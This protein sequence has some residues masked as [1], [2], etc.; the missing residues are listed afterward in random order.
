[1]L[2]IS[3]E[4]LSLMVPFNGK[5]SKIASMTYVPYMSLGNRK[6]KSADECRE[7]FIP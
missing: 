6:R 7:N 2:Y 5:E 4:Q 3:E 1:M